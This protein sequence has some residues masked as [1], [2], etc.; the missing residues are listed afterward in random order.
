MADWVTEIGEEI[1]QRQEDLRRKDPTNP[2]LKMVDVDPN[3]GLD[4]NFSTSP[5]GT[6]YL[7]KPTGE[8]LRE[9]ADD[10][11]RASE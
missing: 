2:L 9:Y 4:Y 6:K 10:L 7:G 3:W 8:S 1:S 11:K 5:E